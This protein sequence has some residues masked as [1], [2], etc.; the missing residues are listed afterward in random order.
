MLI[1]TLSFFDFSET[2]E[3]FNLSEDDV[4]DLLCELNSSFLLFYVKT[5]CL[6]FIFWIK[7]FTL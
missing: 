2:K 1:I 6:L 3:V 5:I 7:S 4:L